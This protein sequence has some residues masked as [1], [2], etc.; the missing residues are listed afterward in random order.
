MEND[1]LNQFNE[2]EDTGEEKYPKGI[3]PIDIAKEVRTSFLDY[4]MSVIVA[5]ALPDARDGFKPVHR[6]IIY[7]MNDLSMHAD[8]PH[9][10]SA[11]IV[12]EVIGK[13]HPHGDSAVYDAMVRLAQDFSIRYP[14]IDGHGN[15]GSIDGDMA[16]AMRYTE[17]R[18]SKI[19]MEMV[20]DINKNTVD[21]VPNYDG[22]EKE[23]SVMPSKFPNLLVNGTTGIAVGMATNMAPHNLGEVIDACL[24]LARDPSLSVIELMTDYIQGPDFPTGAQILGKSGIKKAYE[25]GNGSITIRSKCEIEEMPN[26]RHRIVVSEIPYQVNKSNMVEKIADLVRNKT[27]EGISDIRDESNREGIRVVIEL[28]KDVIPEVILNNLYKLTPLQS[29]YS[30]NMLALDKGEP[31]I[32][33]IKELI[34]LY[35]E[36]QISVITRRTQYDLDKASDRIHIL[37]GLAIAINNIDA[38]IELIKASSNNEEASNNLMETYSLSQKQAKAILE[39]RL[40]RLTG[41]ER[42]KVEEEINQLSALIADLEGILSSHDRVI[43]IMEKELLDVKQRYGDARRTEILIGS[44]DIEDEDLIPQEDI[45]I[46]LTTNGYIKRV[47]LDTYRTQNRG[48]KGVKGMST[49]Q[50]DIVCNLLTTTTHIDIL[51]FTNAGK[52]Y[53]VRGYNIPEFSRQHKGLPV[54]NL[55]GMSRDEKVMA[56]L[57]ID[58]YEDVNLLFVTKNGITKRVMGSEFANIRQNGKIALTLNENDELFGVKVTHGNEEVLIASSLG[59]VVRFN[60]DEVRIMGRNAIGVRGIDVQE[61]H[62]VG[63]ATSSEGEYVLSLSANGFGKMS[64][65]E[66]YRLTKR[67]GKGVLT[68]N[69]TERVGDLVAMR[70]VNGDEDLIIITDKGTML[71]I[72]LTQVAISGRNTQGVRIIRLDDDQEIASIEVAQQEENDD[73]QEIDSTEVALQEESNNQ[74]QEIIEKEG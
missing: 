68:L 41:L 1:K 6:R 21:F 8:K 60:E 40:Q 49:H 33:S 50:D 18:M 57:A 74:D 67:G 28:K 9:K 70:A 36:H 29:R 27:L 69:A 10:K 62:V 7:A 26:G 38:I 12:G 61:G 56:M 32:L 15:F 66:D 24:A 58:K 4:S 42:D 55:L 65:I 17:A 47:S 5:R 3:V 53:R 19:A 39:M 25:T 11:R 44:F 46:S 34:N 13:Y 54:I 71:R 20:K 63:F 72:P 2:V 16:A 73:D 51:F 35:V 37:Q 23:P 45:V 22:E 48:G 59:K 64:K 31:R 30:I 14:L 52:V 43:D